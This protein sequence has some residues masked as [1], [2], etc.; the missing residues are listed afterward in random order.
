MTRKPSTGSGAAP[1]PVS[2][3]QRARIAL[4]NVGIFVPAERLNINTLLCAVHRAEGKPKPVGIHLEDAII[5][6]ERWVA[7]QEATKPS[8]PRLVRGE[9]KFD[10]AMKAQIER[11]NSARLPK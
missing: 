8:S 10:K 11:C 4:G 1:R 2:L 9:L 3:Y 7:E 5:R 6:I